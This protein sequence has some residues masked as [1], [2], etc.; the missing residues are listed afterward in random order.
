MTENLFNIVGNTGLE[1]K[2]SVSSNA[3]FAPEDAA[4]FSQELEKSADSQKQDFTTEKKPFEKDAAEVLYKEETRHTDTKPAPNTQ[5]HE[6]VVEE[7]AP[8]APHHAAESTQD[9]KAEQQAGPNPIDAAVELEEIISIFR[10]AMT[11]K[12]SMEEMKKL[13]IAFFPE[14]KEEDADDVLLALMSIIQGT[15]SKKEIEAILKGKVD[16]D[17]FY[18]LAKLVR[19]LA[20]K[21]IL[22][23]HNKIN[24][25]T[26]AKS[27]EQVLA[28]LNPEL[29]ERLA[30]ARIES[31]AT[32]QKAGT[33]KSLD[34]LGLTK[35]VKDHTNKATETRLKLE[36]ETL[37]TMLANRKSVEAKGIAEQLSKD[38]LKQAQTASLTPKEVD[39]KVDTPRLS[40][41][42]SKDAKTSGEGAKRLSD[43]LDQNG[44]RATVRNDH[45]TQPKLGKAATASTALT[46]QV[47][48]QNNQAA[49]VS[50]QDLSALKNTSVNMQAG[51]QGMAA[52][53]QHMNSVNNTQQFAQ[54]LNQTVQQ[55][56]AAEQVAITLSRAVKNG[57]DKMNVKLTPADLGTVDVELS[58]N[59]NG[60]VKA[61]L[62]IDKPETLNLMQRDA[63]ALQKALEQAGLKTDGNSLDFNLKGEGQQHQQQAHQ[64]NHELSTAQHAGETHDVLEKEAA[65][66][67]T[68]PY[69]EHVI[70][71]KVNITV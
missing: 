65:A 6:N 70:D 12:A 57:Q 43:V 16:I 28:K 41:I 32:S 19:K 53:N 22:N 48:S 47:I 44:L 69:S 36:S 37:N 51:V 68:S 31:Q 60:S 13:M 54:T 61:V 8:A 58:F 33:L 20:G 35:E 4:K 7:T 3:M 49:T 56:P 2:S 67:A 1:K 17:N 25:Q 59:K 15:A 10:K 14:V 27:I 42:A 23:T 38:S 21:D 64:N 63:G 52:G 11:G 18:E 46:A 50:S 9:M 55:Q 71:G 30:T 62:S 29:L 39:T 5:D 26:V 34:E 45:A 40:P 24:D 66:I